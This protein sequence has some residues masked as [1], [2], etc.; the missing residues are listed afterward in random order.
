M[1]PSASYSNWQ[2]L[3]GTKKEVARGAKIEEPTDPND[4]IEVVVRLKR[5]REY[6]EKPQAGRRMSR[7]DHDRDYGPRASDIDAVSA[8]ATHFGLHVKDI[9][10][11]QRLMILEGR[12]S[13]FEKAFKVELH[14]HR[15]P[16][17]QQYRGRT[18]TIQVPAEIKD[19]LAGVFGLDNRRVAWPAI[20]FL[21][22]S[23]AAAA[24]GGGSQT[25]GP[26]TSFYANALAKL[27]NFPTNVDGTG[28]KIGI[29]ELG[30]GYVASDL[31]KYYDTAGL[32]KAPTFSVRPVKDGATNTPDPNNPDLPD[33]EVLLDMEVA[34]SV[35]P[36]A[37]LFM[38]FVKDGSD[39]QVLLG[40]SAAVHDNATDLSVMSLS[41]GGPEY[42]TITMG[43]GPGTAAVSQYQE[44]INDL[45][46]T[47]GHLGITV[48]VATGD[49][50]SAGEAEQWDGKAHA[51][52]PASRPYALAVGGTH[53]VT[54]TPGDPSEEAWHPQRNVGTGGG[55]SRYFPL[56]DYQEKLVKQKAVNPAG[57]L[58]RGIPDVCGDAA[59]ESGYRVLVDG[60]WWPDQAG[61]HP[62]IG[63]TSASTPLWAGLIALFNQSLGKRVGYVTPLLY[64]IGSPSNAF[65]DVTKGNN[66][67]YSAA[68]GWDAC[69]GL[70]SPNGVELLNA[71]KPLLP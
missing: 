24:A 55:I 38:Y 39:A 8:F 49:Q 33:V 2:D 68:N 19:A 54:A 22:S 40:I 14:Q 47:A 28:Q 9:A 45:F 13:A 12:V 27:Y 44:N 37:Q 20:R 5:K 35:A 51:G 16:D 23:T 6:A 17:G 71:L 4:T 56:P 10:D 69:T 58:G 26:I 1:A 31:A 70:G 52:F 21:K 25:P 61:D 53:I 7:A 29:V 30:G 15:F 57:G 62:P 32:K 46:E 42:D 18:G 63:G 64:E 41:F 59:Q 66:G 65:F 36:G 3:P 60:A 67:D 43:T 48:C 50:A 34:G 11:S